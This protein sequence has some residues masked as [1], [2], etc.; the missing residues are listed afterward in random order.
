MGW[1]TKKDFKT[2]EQ[3]EAEA[4]AEKLKE[5]EEWTENYKVALTKEFD[6]ATAEKIFKGEVWIGMSSDNLI[7]MYGSASRVEEKQLKTKTTK[8]LTYFKT[9]YK[10][11]MN[12]KYI[13]EDD[14]LV[15]TAIK[16]EKELL[17]N[18]LYPKSPIN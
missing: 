12:N 6:E 16:F 11:T 5:R 15:R 18:Q 1:F 3:K 2:V 9:G 4:E 8:T 10:K 14:K 17:W 7:C 13:F